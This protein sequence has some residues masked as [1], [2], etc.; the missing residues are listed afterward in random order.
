LDQDGFIAAEDCDDMN[1]I[2]NPNAEEIPFNE[3]DDDCDEGTLDDDGDQD[4]YSVDDDCDDENPD[5]NPEA[6]EI[7]N[8]GI[9]ENCDGEDL[10]SSTYELSNSKISIF[11]NPAIHLINIDVQGRLSYQ[12]N[13]Y[14]YTG[15]RIATHD[16]IDI[17]ILDD[18]QEGIYL[19]ELKDQE[20][21][22]FILE[23][24]AVIR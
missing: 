10:V 19:L 18:Y 16:N 12:V 24:V 2:I 11:P 20:S 17:I 14:D 9:D 6:E 5:I 15:N 7:A 3:I 23:R 22:A 13:M 4:G 21:K 1:A 8:N